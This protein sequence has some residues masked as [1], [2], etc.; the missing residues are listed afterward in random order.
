MIGDYDTELGCCLNNLEYGEER[1]VD[2]RKIF[3]YTE[4]SLRRIRKQ[5]RDFEAEF[6]PYM[7]EIYEEIMR[8]T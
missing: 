7:L 1:G 4:E 6:N 5:I 3:N 2:I 8:R